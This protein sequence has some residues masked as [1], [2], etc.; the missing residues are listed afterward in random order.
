MENTLG[1]QS[2]SLPH[3]LRSYAVLNLA[4]TS[5]AALLQAAAASQHGSCLSGTLCLTAAP[6]DSRMSAQ[7]GAGSFTALVQERLMVHAQT[8]LSTFLKQTSENQ[9]KAGQ[10]L[11][12]C[13]V[14]SSLCSRC[15]ALADSA[16]LA[17]AAP[18][19]CAGQRAGCAV[20]VA[21]SGISSGGHAGPHDGAQV[22]TWH[23]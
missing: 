11:C 17:A 18:Q 5:L 10:A 23:G 7:L 20:G 15:A 9:L 8:C 12:Q 4:W 16:V 14:S 19:S 13:S 1:K 21:Q 22:R 2:G 3:E 6:G